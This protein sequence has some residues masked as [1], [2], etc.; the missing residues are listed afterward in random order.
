MVSDFI[1]EIKFLQLVKR[2]IKF[3]ILRYSQVGYY[4]Q[5]EILTGCLKP[6]CENGS[7]SQAPYG[8][9]ARML[10]SA[11]GLTNWIK[12]WFLTNKN[13]ILNHEKM[14][15]EALTKISLTTLRMV[16]RSSCNSMS[17]V[18]GKWGFFLSLNGKMWKWY[19]K[20]CYLFIFLLFTI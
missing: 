11:Q 1:H 19:S 10:P 14:K 18:E 17:K 16:S 6:T 15:D 3:W 13:I 7:F 2:C 12:T 8:P 20:F 9:P 5:C 4:V